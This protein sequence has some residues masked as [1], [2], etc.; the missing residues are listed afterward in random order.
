MAQGNLQ[1]PVAKMD[2]HKTAFHAGSPGLYEFTRMPFGLSNSGSSFFPP[3]G[4]V[5]MGPA[6]CH[7]A[8]LP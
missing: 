6:V 4:D 2:I 3:D 5:F 8:V 7:L 1:M